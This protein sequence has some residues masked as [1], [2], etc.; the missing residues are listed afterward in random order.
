M[1]RLSILRTLTMSMSR[2]KDFSLHSLES[3]LIVQCF[4]PLPQRPYPRQ[5]LEKNYPASPSHDLSL[6][7]MGGLEG[8]LNEWYDTLPPHLRLNFAQGK[9]STDITGS[10]SPLLVS[11]IMIDVANG[12]LILFYRL[13]LIITFAPLFTDLLLGQHWA[14]RLHLPSFRSVTRAST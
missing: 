4:G 13:W 9:P 8:E 6:Q 14:R 7:Q 5:S 11:R 3:I 10:R 1:F 12:D 2:R